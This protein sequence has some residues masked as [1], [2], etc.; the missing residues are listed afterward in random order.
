MAGHKMR[1]D[2]IEIGS[3]V[4]PYDLT[5][6]LYLPVNQDQSLLTRPTEILRRGLCAKAGGSVAVCRSCPGGC[7]IGKELVRRDGV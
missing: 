5:P 4:Q 3:Y 7:R 2:D 6:E 1:T